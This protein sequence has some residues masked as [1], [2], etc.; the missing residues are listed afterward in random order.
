VPDA[1]LPGLY[2]AADLFVYPSRYE[3]FGLPP[4]EAM[5]YGIPVVAGRARSLPEDLG[6]AALSGH[7]EGAESWR[8]AWPP[9]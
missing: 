3:A 7:P 6:T 2:R 1:D 8:R 4:L 9:H 5:A